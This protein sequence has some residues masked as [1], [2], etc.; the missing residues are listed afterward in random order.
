MAPPALVR[1]RRRALRPHWPG[2]RQPGTGRPPG[3]RSRYGCGGRRQRGP[4]PGSTRMARRDTPPPTPPTCILGHQAR[5]RV[6]RSAQPQ[7]QVGDQPHPSARKMTTRSCHPALGRCSTRAVHG[8]P[9]LGGTVY[10]CGLETGVQCTERGPRHC[11]PGQLDLVNAVATGTGGSW[12]QL[13]MVTAHS[14]STCISRN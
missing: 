11:A 10:A 13:C 3:T 8:S 12:H 1:H 2:G 6:V 4:R 5:P 14:S 7:P 9:Q